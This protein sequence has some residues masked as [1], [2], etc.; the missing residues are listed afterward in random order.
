MTERSQSTPNPDALAQSIQ[1]RFASLVEERKLAEALMTA[2]HETA[3]ASGRPV[4]PEVSGAVFARTIAARARVEGFAEAIRLLM[5]DE[6]LTLLTGSIREQPQPEAS[7]Q[8][9]STPQPEPPHRLVKTSAAEAAAP[10]PEGNRQPEVGERGAWTGRVGRQ[11][12]FDKIPDGRIRGV[13]FL[14]HHPDA[15]DP[16]KTDWL[17]CYSLGRHAEALQKKG[18][19]AGAEVVVRGTLQGV[20]ALARADGTT[21]EQPTVY[22]YGVRLVRGPKAGPGQNH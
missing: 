10:L 7:P 9:E 11:P 18:R 22:V 4:S 20:R 14:A 21:V 8:P 15:N 19:L 6:A 3:E 16:E 13:F 12:V 2:T 17:R 5:G 1:A